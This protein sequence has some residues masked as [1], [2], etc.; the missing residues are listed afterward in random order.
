MAFNVVYVYTGELFPTKVRQSVLGI[1]MIGARLGGFLAP[2][3]IYVGKYSLPLRNET[4]NRR[5]SN[6][7]TLQR[8]F[9][10]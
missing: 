7:S 5:N 9:A 4:T 6:K 8:I 1:N 10:I 2:F 3:L